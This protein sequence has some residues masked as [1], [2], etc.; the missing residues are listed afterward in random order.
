ML[1]YANRAL[2]DQRIAV[3][4]TLSVFKGCIFFYLLALN[5]LSPSK[6]H[7]NKVQH[8]GNDFV[9]W[10]KRFVKIPSASKN[11]GYDF[12]GYGNFCCWGNNA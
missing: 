11:C 10:T 6:Q 8:G 5:L 7:Q 9:A 4:D 1:D 12:T 2:K 3:R